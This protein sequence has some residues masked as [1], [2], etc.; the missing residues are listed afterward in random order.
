MYIQYNSCESRKD[1]S[2]QEF[3]RQIV[4]QAGREAPNKAVIDLRDNGGGSSEISNPL[5][6]AMRS[7]P[8]LK[9]PG[10]VFV[11]TGLGTYSSGLIVALRF[12]EQF[13]ALVAGEP[14]AE[15]PNHYGNL[16]SLRLPNSG[17]TVSYSTRYFAALED[18]P[19]TLMP[20]LRIAPSAADYFGGRDPVMDAVL[21]LP[22]TIEESF[23]AVIAKEPGN[24]RAYI[25]LAKIDRSRA[26]AILKDGIAASPQ[27]AALRLELA[28]YY[29]EKK[30]YALARDL[31]S[32][33]PETD[34]SILCRM[35]RLYLQERNFARAEDAFLKCHR[36]EPDSLHGLQGA[37]DVLAAQNKMDS[38][39]RL[40]DEEA[41]K[42]SGGREVRIFAGRLAA[43]AGRLDVAAAQ[44]ERAIAETGARSPDAFEM[45][46]E[47]SEI[48]RK[49]GDARGAIRAF[50][51]DMDVVDG[52][53]KTMPVGPGMLLGYVRGFYE[54][55]QRREPNDGVL[56]NNL[57]AVLAKMGTNL[58][59]AAAMA[60]QS[61]QVLP[62]ILDVMDNLGYVYLKQKRTEQALEALRDAANRE[63]GNSR[64]RLHFAMALE[65][66]GNREGAIL[67][68]EAA[69]KASDDARDQVEEMLRKLAPPSR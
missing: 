52:M 18:N 34:A 31:L 40:L 10:G 15:R 28:G 16:R 49:K 19:P 24:A 8:S 56:L 5:I 45:W 30:Q 25:A 41:A 47:L 20:E 2:F 14:T 9:P 39:W 7:N 58:D 69:L 42:D 17:M 27:S 65:A 66:S 60:E 36:L 6:E 1:L 26:E 67:E 62:E 44:Y 63:P 50:Q 33:G 64:Y 3:T 48:Y 55:A 61:R 68:L 13:Q 59:R 43:G 11:L 4:E 21:K 12:R 57:S 22:G 32:A 23:R 53:V 35:G 38:A 46:M 54:Q 51:K 37:V 29:G